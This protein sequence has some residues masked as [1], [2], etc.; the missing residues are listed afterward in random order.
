MKTC[1]ILRGIPGS[2]KST[3]AREMTKGGGVIHSTD[4][5]FVVNGVYTFIPHLLQINHER[6]F[7]SFCRSVRLGKNPIV[8]DN[9]NHLIA[10]LERYREYAGRFGYSVK[11]IELPMLTA[12]ESV[13]RSVHSI[14]LYTVQRMIETWEPLA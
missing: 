8:V 14:S 2:G 10:H 5:F 12:E 9:C 4:D 3:K 1:F 13:A 11:I 6:N 7:E